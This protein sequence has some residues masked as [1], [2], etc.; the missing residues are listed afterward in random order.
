VDVV[1]EPG[2]MPGEEP[3]APGPEELGV[4]FGAEPAAFGAES[5]E[6]LQE[7]LGSNPVEE[8]RGPEEG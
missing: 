7:V 4:A 8:G 6:P 3:A 2:A 5:G 1:G